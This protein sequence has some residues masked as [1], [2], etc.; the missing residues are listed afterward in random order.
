MKEISPFAIIDNNYELMKRVYTILAKKVKKITPSFDFASFII[1][2]T[3]NSDELLPV[4]VVIFNKDAYKVFGFF[5]DGGVVKI[6]EGETN[7]LIPL[8]NTKVQSIIPTTDM[9]YD[10]KNNKIKYIPWVLSKFIELKSYKEENLPPY[11]TEDDI[12][13]FRLGIDVSRWNVKWMD[14]L[15]VEEI[16]SRWIEEINPCLLW[17]LNFELVRKIWA[18]NI[19]VK[20]YQYRPMY[21]TKEIRNLG[22]VGVYSDIEG[23]YMTVYKDNYEGVIYAIGRG[24]LSTGKEGE[25]GRFAMMGIKIKEVVDPKE[26]TDIDTLKTKLKM[27]NIKLE[28]NEKAEPRENAKFPLFSPIPYIYFLKKIET[29]KTLQKIAEL[30][31]NLRV[32]LIGIGIAPDEEYYRGYDEYVSDVRA[33]AKRIGSLILSFLIRGKKN[34]CLEGVKNIVYK[35]FVGYQKKHFDIYKFVD[36][37]LKIGI[38]DN[39]DVNVK[40]VGNIPK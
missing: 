4:G 23:D 17:G 29:D 36:N 8:R 7:G 18:D 21:I 12:V 20:V 6:R 27:V 25:Y 2:D 31:K 30:Q 5:K 1:I 39:I 34:E 26:I 40:W 14:F 19:K 15:G 37:T 13:S 3:I 35:L 10:Y 38:V 11:M 9:F 33:W 24:W 16:V 28:L 32:S 22:I